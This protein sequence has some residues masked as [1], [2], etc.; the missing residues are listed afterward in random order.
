MTHHPFFLFPS[1]F[2]LPFS[3]CIRLFLFWCS[4]K[5]LVVLVKCSYIFI[6]LVL[7][8]IVLWNTRRF[9][10]QAL[11]PVYYYCHYYF[12]FFALQFFLSGEKKAV[13]KKGEKKR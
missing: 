12:F 1:V 5:R 4:Q 10:F 9:F 8:L 3:F 7:C 13:T 11:I 6:C 2:I